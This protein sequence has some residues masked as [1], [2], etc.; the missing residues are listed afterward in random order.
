MKNG[1]VWYYQLEAEGVG[2]VE[3]MVEDFPQAYRMALQLKKT[4][5]RERAVQIAAV[6]RAAGYYEVVE[7]L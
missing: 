3:N 5:H 1:D 6:N 2:V 4:S 7:R